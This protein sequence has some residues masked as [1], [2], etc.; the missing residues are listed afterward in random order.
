M[1]TSV[2]MVAAAVLLVGG[3]AYA[4]CF[5]TPDIEDDCDGDGCR[6][7]Y[8]DCN[9]SPDGGAKQHGVCATPS[10]TLPALAEVCDGIDN[11][12]SG[13]TDE[14]DPG[15]GG[16]CTV[17]GGKGLCAPGVYHCQSAAVQC[18][19]NVGPVT[20]TCDGFDN[21]CDG[22]TDEQDSPNQAQKLVQTC[23]DGPGTPNVGICKS[24]QQA[25][26]AAADA[27]VASWTSCGGCGA[28]ATCASQVVG[29]NPPAQAEGLCNGK[30][31]DC[32][33]TVDDGNP[34]GGMS[35][36]TGKSGVCAA[37]TL[38]CH[39]D[40]GVLCDQNVNSSNEVCDGRD[41]DCDGDTDE[42][43]APG[44]DK[45]VQSC[46]PFGSGTPG[47]GECKSGQQACNAPANNGSATWSTCGV[48]GGLASCLTPVGPTAEVCDNKDNDCDGTLNNGNP[49]G[50]GACTSTN[51]GI[52][53]PG[54]NTCR[55]VNDA[56]VIQCVSNVTPG[57]VAET[58][59]GLDNDCDGDTDESG[60]VGSSKL[61][62]SCYP[63]PA[64]TYGT[65]GSGTN[66]CRNGTQACNAAAGSGSASYSTC[67][68]C[69][70][71]ASCVMPITAV[72]TPNQ[73][74][75]Y[76]NGLNEN[77]DSL[78]VDNGFNVGGTCVASGVGRCASGVIACAPDAGTQCNQNSP[79]AETCNKVD[80]NCNGSTDEGDPGGGGTCPVSGKQGPCAV[81]VRHCQ[82]GSLVCP[83]ITFPGMETCN[84]IDDDC[85]GTVDDG[86]PQ[87]GM[88]CSTAGLG[89]CQPGHWVCNGTSLQC[90]ANNTPQPES[91]DGKDNDCN[92]L[93]DDN[94]AAR[95]C[96]TGPVGTYGGTCPGSS[97]TPF[98]DCRAGTQ[99]CV[100]GG[101]G[102]WN[103]CTGV[104]LPATEVCDGVHDEDCDGNID[105]GL[106]I[107]KDGDGSRACGTCDAPAAPACDCNDNPDGGAAI[108][109]GK[110]ELCNG[111]DDNCNGN[112]DEGSGPTGKISRNCYSG[113]ANTQGKGI[114]V[115]GTQECN[116]VA[117]G[118]ESY[119]QCV[120][121]V[122]PVSSP[123]AGETLCNGKDDNCNG[124][125]DDGFDNDNDGFV[126]CAMCSG[127]DGGLCDCN[128]GD[129]G[130]KPGAVEVCDTVDNNCNGR[131]DDVPPRKCF[132]DSNGMNE[133]P[134]TYTGTCPGPTCTP[135][136]ACVAG[137]QTCTTAGAWGGCASVV[138]P[139]AEAC[140]GKDDDCN[141][142]VDDANFDMDGD[143]FKSCALCM[144]LDGGACDCNDNDKN[145]HPGAPEV[146]DNVDNDCDGTT[147]GVNTACYSGPANTRG[148]GLCHDGTQACSGGVGTGACAGEVTPALLPDGGVPQYADGGFN[149]PE[150]LCDGKDEDCDGVVDDGFD[151][152]GDGQTTCQG[153]CDDKD[154]F[155]KVGGA[156]IC[157]CKDNNCNATIDDNN[158]CYG[159]PCHDLDR[160]GFT[161]C[162]GDCNDTPGQGEAIG[163]TRSEKVGDGVDNDCDGAIDEDT[164]EDGDG[165]STGQ[166]DCDDHLRDINPGALEKCDGFDNNCNN[167]VDEGFDEDHDFVAVCAGD[168]DDHNADVSPIR[169]EVCGNG[170]D[171]NC[172][173]RI[174]EETDV[175]GDGVS[176]CQGDCNDY[177][178]AVH[179]AFGSV[180]AAAEVCDGQ[181]NDC[182]FKI[183]EGFDV[184]GDHVSACFGDCDDKDPAVNPF[185]VEV[186]GNGKDDN[187][188]GQVDE[189]MVDRDG[190]GFSPNCGD[191][192]DSNPA[193]NPHA[194]EVC[195]RVDNNCDGYVDSAKGVYNLCAVCFDADGD[196]QTN[197]DGDCNDAD[198]AV[199]RGAAEICDGKDNDCDG[200]LDLDPVTG[201]KVC[202]EGDDGGVDAGRPDSGVADAGAGDAGSVVMEPG[203][204]GT[205]TKDRSVISTG[206]GCNSSDGA[207]PLALVA[208]GRRRRLA[209]GGARRGSGGGGGLGVVAGV[210]VDARGARRQDR[211]RHLA[212]DRRRQRGRRGVRRRL[213]AAGRELAVPRVGAGRALRSAH[214]D[215]DGRLCAQP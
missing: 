62:R 75:L 94:V 215:H 147:D 138:L 56:G 80:D 51:V 13:A 183:D 78:G 81:G 203:D 67:G 152:D 117:G 111:L 66:T 151:L 85:N 213:H 208:L 123:D 44:S 205:G 134:N 89:E 18:V 196:G 127:F 192:N 31:D 23:F 194:K 71:L 64:S 173:G 158:A 162:E 42:Q 156:E 188:N 115:A 38:Q 136:G 112:V 29:T 105:N 46:Y 68:S 69:P 114:C 155:N 6:R 39:G 25:C 135:N 59:D 30:D 110:L 3:S 91:C 133:P 109:P 22:L 198:K 32:D 27:G 11:N 34:G 70:G 132:S 72:G 169:N 212:G 104:T 131:L 14:G 209:V 54:T 24:G 21:D 83:Q 55:V 170:K 98:G 57:T 171:D 140:N 207:A 178:P 141:G 12:C 126:S 168:C 10:G 101:T 74:E 50:G 65:P 144:P 185:Q 119:G 142:T 189:G 184:D 36:S 167:Q 58:C 128:D 193:V 2:L 106:I 90:V 4:N 19:G 84:G 60:G 97:C 145:V 63:T 107:D 201:L 148:K 40:A 100:S 61:T 5:G 88:A 86:I 7:G 161:N 163:P 153:D 150:L 124:A 122:T 146:C 9:D 1:R 204:A 187:C 99:T 47:V 26:N 76:C 154:P 49:G 113:P 191:C 210:P 129:F 200:M 48:C 82:G 179:P 8:G 159:A 37:G 41:N 180:A 20:E 214:T 181:D 197:C 182:N 35:C 120:G 17:P 52:C 15:G 96:Y 174:D 177:N 149:E 93:V 102:Q 130:I 199:Y 92:G 79:V 202:R 143:G 16:A 190:D 164:D 87:V 137:T 175:D 165:W 195:D 121:Q 45:L 73:P 77:C 139:M 28:L 53:A 95:K 176:T 186:P 172:D 103:A 125:V 116:A 118:S 211:W 157:D 206:C 43:G 160:D 33:G 108:K 166:G